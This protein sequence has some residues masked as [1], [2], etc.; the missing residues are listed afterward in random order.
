VDAPPKLQTNHASGWGVTG[1][2]HIQRRILSARQYAELRERLRD[3]DDEL[4]RMKAAEHE[5]RR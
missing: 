2:V 1:S 4:R 5:R 3:V